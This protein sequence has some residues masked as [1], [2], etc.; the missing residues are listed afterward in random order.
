MLPGHPHPSLKVRPLQ[1]A[2]HRFAGLPNIERIN[3]PSAFAGLFEIQTDSL[4]LLK[5]TPDH[6]I[7]GRSARAVIV[8]GYFKNQIKYGAA[9]DVTLRR[10]RLPRHDLHAL[11]E[12]VM[13]TVEVLKRLLRIRYVCYQEMHAMK[14]VTQQR[15]RFESKGTGRLLPRPAWFTYPPLF[16]TVPGNLK[17][18]RPAEHAPLRMAPTSG[19]ISAR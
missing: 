1:H 10:Q 11:E 14:R 6:P 9:R 13:E 2:Q 12:S 8:V 3:A 15:I 7:E 17:R 19:M 18:R 5:D 4:H 16:Q